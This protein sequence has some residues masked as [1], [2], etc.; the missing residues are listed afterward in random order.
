ME[1]EHH[2]DIKIPSPLESGKSLKP[3]EKDLSGPG[4]SP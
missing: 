1:A 3:F 2:W 4:K